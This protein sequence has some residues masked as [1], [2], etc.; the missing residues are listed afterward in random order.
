MSG[1][2]GMGI[3]ALSQSLLS[4]DVTRELAQH[5]PDQAQIIIPFVSLIDGDVFR[6]YVA[7]LMTVSTA[8]AVVGVVLVIAA[9]FL[10][11]RRPSTPVVLAPLPGTPA[12][13]SSGNDGTTAPVAVEL[14]TNAIPIGKVTGPLAPDDTSAAT[15]A[16]QF[17]TTSQSTTSELDIPASA[18]TDPDTTAS[19]V[20]SDTQ[21]R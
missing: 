10:T 6:T 19:S 2:G 16:H 18:S 7:W 20:S 3:A 9:L 17:A 8:C 5:M 13:H 12:A 4:I 14:D 15:D 11:P 21:G 1:A